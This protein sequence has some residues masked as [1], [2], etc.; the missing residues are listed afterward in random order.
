MK[1][2]PRFCLLMSALGL[3]WLAFACSGCSCGKDPKPPPKV[4]VPKPECRLNGDCAFPK[5]CV[6]EICTTLPVRPTIRLVLPE[7][8]KDSS[9]EVQLQVF[10]EH[11]DKGSRVQWDGSFL[12]TTFQSKTELV[13]VVPKVE[14]TKPHEVNVVLSDGLS[15]RGYLVVLKKEIEVDRLSFSSI[16]AQCGKETIVVWGRHFW[17]D[18]QAKLVTKD[19]KK[20]FPAEAVQFRPNGEVHLTFD[21]TSIA[22]GSYE[23]VLQNGDSGEAVK[24]PFTV[25]DKTPQP[26]ILSWGP[27]RFWWGSQA[28]IYLVGLHLQHADIRFQKQP[29]RLFS[30]NRSTYYIKIDLNELPRQKEVSHFWLTMRSRCQQEQKFYPV[31]VRDIPKPVI[32]GFSPNV[33]RFSLND[34]VLVNGEGFHPDARLWMNGKEIPQAKRQ[35]L[36]RFRIPQSLLGEPGEYTIQIRNPQFYRSTEVKLKVDHTPVVKSLSPSKLRKNRE[37]KVTIE[38]DNFGPQVQVRVG[39]TLIE[40]VERID[41]TR[42][43]IPSNAFDKAGS[44]DVIVVNPGSPAY[45]SKP[46]PFKVTEGPQIETLSSPL[47]LLDHTQKEVQVVGSDFEEQGTLFVDGKPVSETY[48][49]WVNDKAWNIA[50]G[51]FEKP[52]EY[53]LQV[54]NQDKVLSNKVVL[55][56]RNKE[57]KKILSSIKEI[58]E[59]TYLCGEGLRNDE[60]PLR[61]RIVFRQVGQTKALLEVESSNSTFD[62]TCLYFNTKE[63]EYLE[64]KTYLVLIC[65][66]EDNKTSCSNEYPWQWRGATSKPS[67]EKF[68]PEVQWIRPIQPT[69]FVWP[70]DKKPE[71]YSM[72]IGGKYFRGGTKVFVNGKDAGT[73]EGA[74]LAVLSDRIVLYDLPIP[75]PMYGT[76]HVEVRNQYGKSNTFSF[77][78]TEKESLRILWTPQVF[79]PR[80]DSFNFQF[81]GYNL[82]RSV[83]FFL[84]DVNIKV[85]SASLPWSQFASIPPYF[86]SSFDWTGTTKLKVGMRKVQVK[87]KSGAT[88]NPLWMMA[89]NDDLWGKESLGLQA[90]DDIYRYTNSGGLAPYVNQSVALRMAYTGFV[91]TSGNAKTNGQVIVDGRAQTYTTG[92]TTLFGFSYVQP[93]AIRLTGTPRMVPIVLRNPDKTVSNYD[94]LTVMPAGSYR[95]TKVYNAIDF[96]S[97]VRPDQTVQLQIHGNFLSESDTFYFL[98]RK[99]KVDSHFRDP[100]SKDEFVRITINAG[101]LPDGRYPVWAVNPRSNVSNSLM[102]TVKKDGIGGAPRWRSINPMVLSK[103]AISRAKSKARLLVRAIGLTDQTVLRVGK[104]DYPLQ[105][106]SSEMAYVELDLKDVEPGSID[107]ALH[108]PKEAATSTPLRIVIEE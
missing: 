11:F 70:S 100:D 78:I 7:R 108:N 73:L 57:E 52:G 87:T 14:D 41:A 42:L 21:F 80:D 104:T 63:I 76:H 44:Y 81:Y 90:V 107:V 56:V 53:T 25:Q 16:A 32:K 34:D 67:A 31:E 12:K 75:S 5:Q 60:H 69:S 83:L 79:I 101:D 19:G 8:S 18:L 106:V 93:R 10:G 27:H 24:Q 55:Y 77:S 74:R 45:A 105:R 64:P 51:F 26:Q 38:G 49:Q 40:D 54:Q 29:V 97:I 89:G 46:F 15:S 62:T 6:N 98:G 88:S 58:G 47:L 9:T 94:F 84:D 43:L 17:K 96:S 30:I 59:L 103:T 99:V 3:L 33:V 102:I 91:V 92:K 37:E 1:L 39:E 36:N 85:G 82:S 65:Q 35:N 68:P 66:D 72:M 4:V 20:Q 50:V 22:K 2:Q 23:L 28:Q 71:T 13:A 95:I 86:I 48:A 61:P